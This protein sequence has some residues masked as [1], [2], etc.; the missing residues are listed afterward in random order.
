MCITIII[1]ES[2]Y[3]LEREL[4]ALEELKGIKRKGSDI[5]KF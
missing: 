1:K 3:Q 2:W 5:I 4:G